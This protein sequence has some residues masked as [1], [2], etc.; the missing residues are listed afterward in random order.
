[1]SIPSMDTFLVS[2]AF[3]NKQWYY[4]NVSEINLA[5]IQKEICYFE[6]K[7]TRF[8]SLNENINLTFFFP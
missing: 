1:M 2:E 4:M 5:S 3:E 8:S 6:I 7:G